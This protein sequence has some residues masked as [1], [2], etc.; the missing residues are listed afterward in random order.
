MS[1]F[2]KLKDLRVLGDECERDVSVTCH[3]LLMV[4]VT[5]VFKDILPS[6]RIRE[7]TETERQ[8]SVSAARPSDSSR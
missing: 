4:S 1:Q 2:K 3:K 5:E 6:Y 7:R 8:Q